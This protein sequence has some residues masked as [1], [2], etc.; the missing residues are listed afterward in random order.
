MMVHLLCKSHYFLNCSILKISI[1]F[2]S[3][4]N[5]LNSSKYNCNNDTKIYNIVEYSAHIHKVANGVILDL[6]FV[7]EEETWGFFGEKESE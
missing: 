5:I 4:K 6:T 7:L 3:W 1:K 2:N